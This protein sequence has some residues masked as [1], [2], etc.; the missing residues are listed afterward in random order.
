[1]ARRYGS[2]GKTPGRGFG[3]G[4]ASNAP[5]FSA[6]GRGGESPDIDKTSKV[7]ELSPAD[8]DLQS[9]IDLYEFQLRNL[10][11]E[12]E[13]IKMQSIIEGLGS[14]SAA[15][16]AHDRPEPDFD[17]SLYDCV[18]DFSVPDGDASLRAI[19]DYAAYDTGAVSPPAPAALPA[20]VLYNSF[21]GITPDAAATVFTLNSMLA[22]AERRNRVQEVFI[23]R[24]TEKLNDSAEKNKRNEAAKESGGG[25]APP[26]PGHEAFA[27]DP[28]KDIEMLSDDNMPACLFELAD[29]AEIIM[30]M[31]TQIAGM[32]DT[33]ESMSRKCA[34]F[35]EEKNAIAETNAELKERLAGFHH[36]MDRH[37]AERVG[38]MQRQMEREFELKRKDLEEEYEKL[39]DMEREW[40]VGEQRRAELISQEARRIKAEMD[41]KNSEIERLLDENGYFRALAH[42]LKNSMGRAVADPSPEPSL[43]PVPEGRNE[44]LVEEIEQLL[45]VEPVALDVFEKQVRDILDEAQD[46]IRLETM[47]RLR[48]TIIQ[49]RRTDDGI[50]AL[51]KILDRGGNHKLLPSICVLIGELYIS[52]GRTREAD[53][54]LSHPMAGNDPMAR[55]LLNSIPMDRRQ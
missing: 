53:Y 52:T 1:M 33:I 5:R 42:E 3:G 46:D 14:R 54:Y 29:A 36:K 25:A 49:S 27:A 10:R 43:K 34:G 23:H 2:K 11:R 37:F 13:Q 38:F 7:T 17:H 15:A 55:A 39:V 50:K 19:R 41:E 9:R 30:E 28:I 21:P 26:L 45:E 8:P 18:F 48:K 16:R 32:H 44:V 20:T 24:L 51:L 4:G 22:D 12:L 6:A 31:E 40:R 47:L 35:D